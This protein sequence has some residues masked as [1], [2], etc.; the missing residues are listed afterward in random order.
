MKKTIFTLLLFFIF[1]W[2]K[3]NAQEKTY[4]VLT[5]AFY[6]LENLFDTV[7]DPKKMDERSPIMEIVETKRPE[8]YRKKLT[9]MS[10]VLEQI[11]KEVVQNSP[12]IIGVCEVENRKVLED[13]LNQ[14]ALLDKNYGI[15]HYD[16]PDERGID[17][18]FLYQKAFF[19]PI[20]SSTHEVLIYRNNDPND[21]DFTRD[22]LLV[23][24]MLDNEKMH[25]I[26]NHWPS[27]G[28]GQAASEFKRL[29]AAEVTKRIIDSLQNVDPY[30]KIIA[31]G[32]FNDN[33][34]NK[35]F[36]EV[37]KTEAEKNNVKLKGLYNPFELMHEKGLGTGAYRDGWDNFDQIIL[38]K[39]FLKTEDYSSYRLYRAGIFNPNFLITPRGKYKGYPF[40]SYSNGS[41]SG[42]YSDHFPVYVYL[43][44][45]A[46]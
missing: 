37:L 34:Y 30:A 15:I 6:N 17:V 32:D 1:S 22:Q 8:V 14:P 3:S 29:K 10:T 45:E 43:I 19:R 9:N 7:D 13:L 31:M 20:N 16:S 41:F 26:I 36:K 2:G 40:R 33:P 44:K 4:K 42:G 12:I 5:V 18:A 35:S 21:R 46:K 25:F 27:R 28:G 11:G 38:S 39:P 24:G 23:T